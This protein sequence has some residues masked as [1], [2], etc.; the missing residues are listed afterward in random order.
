MTDAD[1]EGLDLSHW[2]V[3]LC[4]AEPVHP[5]TLDAFADRFACVGFDRRALTPVYGLAEATLAVTFSPIETPPKWRSFSRE[6]L[7]HD[8]L[9]V[10][11]P[12]GRPIPSLGQPIAGNQI[13]IRTE[14]G[15]PLPDGHVG[16]VYARG[17]GIMMGYLDRPDDTRE[18]IDENGWLD[19]G[20]TGFICDQ[21]LYLYGRAKDLI[22][23]NGRN[24]D[25]SLR[26][27]H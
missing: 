9:A 16:H 8:Q 25:P 7:E 10:P 18:A 12:D 13:E 22:I 19:T 24:H 17:P 5:R 27:T 4:G 2:K 26:S 15:V 3:A 20:D 11:C 21:E 6:G 14:H 23:I 1:L